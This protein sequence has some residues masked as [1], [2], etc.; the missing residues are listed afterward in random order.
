MRSIA[1]D[2]DLR[3]P[4]HR[5][6]V[7]EVAVGDEVAQLGHGLF[8]VAEHDAAPVGTVDARDHVEAGGLAGAVRADE[9]VDAPWFDGE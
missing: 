2:F 6:A 9:S 7:E 1:A 3:Q 5:A 4:L 8:D